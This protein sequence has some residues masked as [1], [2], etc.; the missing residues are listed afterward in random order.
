MFRLA[1]KGWWNEEGLSVFRIRQPNLDIFG[2]PGSGRSSASN[3]SAHSPGAVAMCWF[4][5]HRVTGCSSHATPCSPASRLGIPRKGTLHAWT[6]SKLLTMDPSY[7]R[8]WYLLV[9]DVSRLCW[10]LIAM[11]NVVQSCSTLSPP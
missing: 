10:P 6:S 8:A 5:R 2:D 11:V 3:N 1:L 9:H 7:L 4:S